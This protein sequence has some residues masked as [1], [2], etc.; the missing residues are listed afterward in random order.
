MSPLDHLPAEAPADGRSFPLMSEA[1]DKRLVVHPVAACGTAFPAKDHSRRP[2]RLAADGAT[3]LLARG[4]RVVACD[5]RSASPTILTK[6]PNWAGQPGAGSPRGR[7]LPNGNVPPLVKRCMA[8]QSRASLA[9]AP[10]P[11]RYDRVPRLL[12]IGLP[13]CCQSRSGAHG[14]RKDLVPPNH[15][16][17][18][19]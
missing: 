6:I 14:A 17:S 16:M 7:G 5:E 18:H 4:L 12:R 1:P 10:R 2:D 8:K 15:P 9:T 19:P 3:V 13:H 11:R